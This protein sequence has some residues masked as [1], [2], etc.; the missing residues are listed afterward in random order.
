MTLIMTFSDEPTSGV[1]LE[2]VT[3][4]VDKLP[5]FPGSAVARDSERDGGVLYIYYVTR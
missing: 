2:L 4:E 5:G 1:Q 3:P